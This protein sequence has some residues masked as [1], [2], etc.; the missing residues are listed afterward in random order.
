MGEVRAE[1]WRVLVTGSRWWRHRDL[2]AETLAGI[3]PTAICHGGARGADSLAGEWAEA[4]GI[5]VTVYPADWERH[6]RAAGP[7]RNRE[8]LAAFQPDQVV[9]FKDRYGETKGGTED[10]V[11][12]AI[13]A[14]VPAMIVDT[15]PVPHPQRLW[16]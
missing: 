8:M 11:E 2:L 3:E 15:A 10:M 7:I 6:G 5:P 12:A 14:H 4:N 13:A 9:A 16:G 1:Q